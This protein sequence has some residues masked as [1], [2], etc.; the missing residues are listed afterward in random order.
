MPWAWITY[1][2]EESIEFWV[3]NDYLLSIE[4]SFGFD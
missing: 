4:I 2:G 1:D 3:R